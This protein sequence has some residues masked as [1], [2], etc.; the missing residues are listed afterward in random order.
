[1]L[2]NL[3]RTLVDAHLQEAFEL[4]GYVQVPMLTDVEVA[5]L[6]GKMAELRPHDSFAPRGERWTYHCSFVDTNLEY[7]RD[8][9][10]LMKDAFT[11]VLDR[12]LKGYRAISCNFYVKPP[13]RGEL[14]AHQNWPTIADINDTTVSL[15]CPLVDVSGKNGTLQLVRGSHKL[16]PF[17][18]APGTGPCFH[19]F[20]NELIEQY[21]RPMPMAA[22]Q[23]LIFDDSLIHY[24][25]DNLADEP[26]IAVQI[27]CI[28]LDSRPVFFHLTAKRDRFELIHADVEFYLTEIAQNLGTRRPEWSSEGFI[29]NRNRTL[30]LEEFD[31]M[32]M[33]GDEI[34]RSIYR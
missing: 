6:V 14:Q 26:R 4:A 23:G 19:Q 31:D 29:E 21:L 17:I 22:G 20:K 33:N 10:H 18:E 27:V 7:R 24:S 3:R 13:G 1:M 16:L 28:P 9:F 11:P 15:W 12:L 5:D 25:P 8:A 34:R 30:S 32:L 2:H